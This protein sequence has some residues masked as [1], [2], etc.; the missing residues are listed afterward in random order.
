MR[1]FRQ[2]LSLPSLLALLCASSLLAAQELSQ[3]PAFLVGANQLGADGVPE[4]LTGQAGGS[5]EMSFYY[6]SP[7]DNLPG[8]EQYD[9]LQGFSMVICYDCR[10]R[11]DDSSF[12]VVDPSI[13]TAVGVDFIAFQSDNDENDGD[14]CELYLAMLVE[15]TPPFNGSTLPPTMSPLRVATVDFVVDEATVCGEE[16]EVTFCDAANVSG[17][18]P[19]YNV[20]SAENKSFPAETFGTVVAV[21]TAALFLRG[22]CNWDDHF[23]ISDPISVLIIVFFEDFFGQ[24]AICDDACDANDDGRLDLGD[25]LSLL[26]WLFLQGTPP[27]APGTVVPGVDP[28]EDRLGCLLPCE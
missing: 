11:C 20:Y 14:G 28:T 3:Q 23:N 16:L 13:A 8:D 22:D 25:T 12:R 7:E 4:R 1:R 5:V 9:H 27:P 21:D 6:H 17:K 24:T 19:L 26:H 18:V 2:Y 10:L 15:A